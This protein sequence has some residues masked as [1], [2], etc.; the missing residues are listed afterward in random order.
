MTLR[1]C[2]RRVVVTV[3]RRLRQTAPL[4]DWTQWLILRWMTDWRRARTPTE[5]TSS[6]AALLVGSMPRVSRKVHQPLQRDLKCLTDRQAALLQGGPVNR[7]LL[8]VVPV[9]KQLLL[10]A[11]QLRSEFSTGAAWWAAGCM[12]RSDRSPQSCQKCSPAARRR[13]LWIDSGL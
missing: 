2:C 5:K 1:P 10:Q 3:S 6:T 7:S 4:A 11:Q 12:S 13:R 9:A 8:V